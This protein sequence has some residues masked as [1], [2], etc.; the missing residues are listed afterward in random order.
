MVLLCVTLGLRLI[1]TKRCFIRIQA[2]CVLNQRH[3][4]RRTAYADCCHSNY[5]QTATDL[6]LLHFSPY[7]FMDTVK[8]TFRRH[9]Q[10]PSSGK[11][12]RVKHLL[13]A[14]R[15][16][17]LRQR[18]FAQGRVPFISGKRAVFYILNMRRWTQSKKWISPN[19]I[20]HRRNPRKPY[21]SKGSLDVFG[22]TRSVS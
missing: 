12:V 20:Y 7:S 22:L 10:S 1:S 13:N 19:A 9:N 3:K 4:K 16:A 17:N 8:T 18:S 2:A 5:S 14:E 11:R 21:W 15:W 6:Q